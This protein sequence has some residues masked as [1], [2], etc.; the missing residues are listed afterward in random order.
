MRSNYG[1]NVVAIK[2]DGDINASPNAEDVVE[3]G[4][5]IVAIGGTEELSKIEDMFTK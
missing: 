3:P 5:I 1:V 4:D 2:H